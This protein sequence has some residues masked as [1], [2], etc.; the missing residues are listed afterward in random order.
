MSFMNGTPRDS[1]RIDPLI[2]KLREKWKANPDWR[3]GQLMVNQLAHS[4]K[5]SIS[6]STKTRE[7]DLYYIEDEE[8][9]P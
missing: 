1:E 5:A 4:S 6:G 9:F 8:L 2:E 7:V 3:L